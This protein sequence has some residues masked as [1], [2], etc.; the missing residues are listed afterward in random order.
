MLLFMPR[1]FL[2]PYFLGL[3]LPNKKALS[4]LCAEKANSVTSWVGAAW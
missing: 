2:V 4:S 3:A 1:S